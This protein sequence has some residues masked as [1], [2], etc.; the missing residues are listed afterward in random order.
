MVSDWT[1]SGLRIASRTS[2]SDPSKKR[3]RLFAGV[4]I[5]RGIVSSE[6]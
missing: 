6:L 1:R 3:E 2:T 4:R 5:R